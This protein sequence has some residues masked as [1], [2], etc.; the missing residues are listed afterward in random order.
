MTRYVGFWARVLATL[1]DSVLIMAITLPPLLGIY[2]LAYLENNE[3]ISGLADILISNILPMI[4]VILF[5]AKKQATPGKMA[6]S[7]RIVDA[8]TGKAPSVKQCVGRYFAYI[9]SALPLGLGFLWVAFDSKK[10]AWHDK[11]AG[12]VVVKVSRSPKA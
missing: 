10:Q 4:L 11:L 5:W 3:A 7:A 9:L 12:T 1:I 6:V 8:Q 2:G